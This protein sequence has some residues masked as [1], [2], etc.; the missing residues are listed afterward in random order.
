M[1]EEKVSKTTESEE[2]KELQRPSRARALSAFEEMDRF[3]DRVFEDFFPAGWLRPPHWDWPMWS[4]RAPFEG[5]WPRVDVL[6]RDEDIVVHAELPG[7]HKDDLEVSMTNDSLTIKGSAKREETEEKETYYRR[8]LSR[9]TFSRTIGL[10]T[11]V[12]GTRAKATFKDGV[13]ELVL[14]K[15][16]KAKRQTIKVG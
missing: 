6:D 13:L 16:E 12:D 1:A 10:P 4:R 7:V 9:G 5:R 14:P 8:E 2:G 3:M 15:L 11:S